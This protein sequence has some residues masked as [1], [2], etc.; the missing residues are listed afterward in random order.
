MEM[1]IL[2]LLSLILQDQAVFFPV[3][4]DVLIILEEDESCIIIMKI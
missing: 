1:P 2:L 4:K 3:Y